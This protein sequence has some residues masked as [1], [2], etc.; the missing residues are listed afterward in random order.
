LLRSVLVK[1]TRLATMFC[2]Q[3]KSVIHIPSVH[4]T[5]PCTEMRRHLSGTSSNP[6]LQLEDLEI[7]PLQA[8]FQVLRVC[9][10][11]SSSEPCYLCTASLTH[12]SRISLTWL[13]LMTFQI[14]GWIHF[15]KRLCPRWLQPKTSMLAISSPSKIL[16]VLSLEEGPEL[17]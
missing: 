4:L 7:C 16:S 9:T 1:Q 17:D 14:F 5:P 15:P 12:I 6:K 10:K 8:L 11:V 13:L 2:A 3:A